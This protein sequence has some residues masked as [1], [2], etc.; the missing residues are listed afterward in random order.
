MLIKKLFFVKNTLTFNLSVVDTDYSTT[1]YY[2]FI[3]FLVHFKAKMTQ[4]I[5]KRETE[6]KREKR[7]RRKDTVAVYIPSYFSLPC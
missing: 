4:H 6:I 3:I 2:Y 5:P 1:G 7:E